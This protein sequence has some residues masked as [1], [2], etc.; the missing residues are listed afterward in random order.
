VKLKSTAL[1]SPVHFVTDAPLPPAEF[2]TSMLRSARK[3]PPFETDHNTLKF[4]HTNHELRLAG[5]ALTTRADITR[6]GKN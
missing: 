5:R 2:M 4:V 3:T 6:L 1:V